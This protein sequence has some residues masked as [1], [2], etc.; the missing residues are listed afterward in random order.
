MLELLG[1][2]LIRKHLNHKC[3]NGGSVGLAP[4][5]GLMIRSGRME[6]VDQAEESE[7]PELVVNGLCRDAQATRGTLAVRG[8]TTCSLKQD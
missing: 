7:Q 6:E 5:F 2:V 4:G 3:S 8:T 1:V